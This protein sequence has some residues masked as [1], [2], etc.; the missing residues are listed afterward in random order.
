MDWARY[1]IVEV[2]FPPFWYNHKKFGKELQGF[3]ADSAQSKTLAMARLRQL[4]VNKSKQYFSGS[5][6]FKSTNES[7]LKLRHDI[8]LPQAWKRFLII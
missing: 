5:T 1:S 4:R 2:L 6:S 8:S 7:K 3:V